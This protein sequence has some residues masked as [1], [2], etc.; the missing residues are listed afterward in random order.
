MHNIGK[1]FAVL[2]N[3]YA[4]E[5]W[6]FSY[7]TVVIAQIDGPPEKCHP[8]EGAEIDWTAYSG[9]PLLDNYI[10]EDL[11]R[12]EDIGDQLEKQ[13]IKYLEEEEC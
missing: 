9:N 1:K 3:G 10:N 2:I 7:T 13:I 8:A 5:I 12:I 4:A 6:V 11:E